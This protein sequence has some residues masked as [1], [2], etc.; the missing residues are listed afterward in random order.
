MTLVCVLPKSNGPHIWFD[1]VRSFQKSLS[2]ECIICTWSDHCVVILTPLRWLTVFP[3]QEKFLWR[4]QMNL[5]RSGACTGVL[6]VDH[7]IVSQDGHC[8]FVLPNSDNWKLSSFGG[9][10]QLS[11]HQHILG[12]ITVQLW[13]HILNVIAMEGRWCQTCHFKWWAYILLLES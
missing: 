3:T 2:H 12:M 11:G 10:S 7:V 4:I 6:W 1:E 5:R 8:F 13:S 9:C